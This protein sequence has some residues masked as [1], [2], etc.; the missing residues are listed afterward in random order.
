MTPWVHFSGHRATSQRDSFLAPISNAWSCRYVSSEAGCCSY[1]SPRWP[2]TFYGS[3]KIGSDFSASCES[4]ALPPRNSKNAWMPVRT[5]LSSIF[6][7]RSNLTRNR[8]QSGAQCAWIR[9]TWKR[10]SKS[11]RATAKSFSFAVARTKR[12]LR[13]WHYVCK[14]RGSREFD[15][16]RKVS[17]AGVNGVS[18]CRA[19]P[20]RF[21]LLSRSRTRR[22][23][24][25]GYGLF[26]GRGR[27]GQF[28]DFRFQLPLGVARLLCCLGFS[29]HR[30]L[31]CSSFLRHAHASPSCKLAIAARS[32]QSAPKTST[33]FEWAAHVNVVG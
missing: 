16:L 18:P 28:P 10:Q 15:R 9:R 24:M 5:S 3:G 29:S 20:K 30:F 4:R 26:C 32:W 13:K 14:A 1:C 25:R 2:P 19:M 31:C 8:K 33:R 7:T 6:G 11:S 23:R 21:N 22:L 17:R 27:A 12:L